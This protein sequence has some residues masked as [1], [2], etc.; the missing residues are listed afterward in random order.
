MDTTPPGASDL[1]IPPAGALLKTPTPTFDWER[2]PGDVIGY[3]I[4]VTSGDINSGEFDIDVVLTG[5]ITE[6]L[7][8][9]QNALA[10]TTYQW[11]VIARDLALNTSSSVTR[12]FTVDTTPPGVT[13]LVDPADGAFININRPTFLWNP[14]TGDVRDYLLQVIASGKNFV[15]GPFVIE[16]LTESTEFKASSI[17]ADGAYQWR[18][19][20]RDLA[21]NRAVSLV[22]TFTVDTQLPGAPSLIA[23]ADGPFL[24]DNTPFFDWDS[25]TLQPF[26]YRL[27][28]TSGDSTPGRTL[29]TR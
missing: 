22:R 19:I 26:G 21:L 28:V 6:F 8:I 11:K 18:V 1:I 10:D 15:S 7:V 9:P 29:S 2:S 5:D 14:A 17:L 24:K 3:R 12:T 27:Q 4:Q 13:T 16:V 20:A 23:P 25:S